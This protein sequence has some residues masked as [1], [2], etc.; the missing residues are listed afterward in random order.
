MD[1][2]AWRDEFPILARSTYLA[3]CSLAPLSRRVRAAVEDFL[4]RWD[5]MGAAAWYTDWLAGLDALR[6]KFARVLQAAPDE[7]A[8]APS[9][10]VALS[11]V[12]SCF[13]Y[14]DRNEVVT[15][16]L[17]FP[18]V[19]YQFLVKP[20]VDVRFV[21]TPDGFGAVP[22]A[23]REA[24]SDRT[25]LVAT[26]H[27]VFTSGFIQDVRRIAAIARGAG[28][29]SVID[30][31]Q[32]VGQMPVDVRELN[33]DVLIT[34]GLKWLLGGT[35][36]AYLYARRE[37]ADSLRPTITGW[38]ANARQF[39]F[40]SRTF[41]YRHGAGRFE[42]GTPSLA[43]V[44]AGSAG[45]DLVLEIGVDR[46]RERTNEMSRDLIERA[47]DAGFVVKTPREDSRRA[48]IVMLRMPDPGKAVGALAKDGIIVDYRHD[49]LRASPYFFTTAEENQRL[50]DGA[51]R[52]L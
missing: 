35:G 26:S 24:V 37:L 10:S 42:L 38:F 34:G 23:F 41:E 39:E 2:T 49:R 32:S 51:K 46:I 36:I 43:A 52:Y 31:Y 5:A 47:L 9:V 16:G 22:E 11:C 40:D 28:A 17:D 33:V 20:R 29:A 45:L 30:A 25:A 12:A 21:E 3:T 14:S 44:A 15:S 1:W 18:T 19:P 4:D 6:G 8:I 27:V 50:V 48:G 13:D 7:I